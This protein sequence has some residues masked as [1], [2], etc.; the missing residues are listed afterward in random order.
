MTTILSGFDVAT[1]SGSL[2]IA[3][4]SQ[5]GALIASTNYTYYI[6]YVSGYGETN[7]GFTGSGTA[8]SSGSLLV[9]GIPVPSAALNGNIAGK[10]IY[11]AAGGATT[12]KLVTT[13]A[14]SA[15]SYIDIT[16]EA[17]LGT[18]TLPLTNTAHSIQTASGFVAFSQP[19]IVSVSA[20]VSG[21]ADAQATAVLLTKQL[22]EVTSGAAVRLPL[23]DA[24]HVG[25]HLIVLNRS[26]GSI[27][28]YPAT[29]QNINR[30]TANAAVAMADGASLNFVAI[31]ATIW[32]SY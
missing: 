16:A 8:T 12:Y 19:H 5:S 23:I 9:S 21:G 6:T 25:Q 24:A 14:P 26:G 4:S 28:V 2:T 3:A 18:A 7:S 17:S 10:R 29:G 15:T 32:R 20:A 30:G 27:N 13:I 22:T 11:R 1:P 31:T